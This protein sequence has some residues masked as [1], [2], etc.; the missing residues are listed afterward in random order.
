M[1]YDRAR[2]VYVLQARTF[3]TGLAL[4][5][6][7]VACG[8]EVGFRIPE[9]TGLDQACLA[10]LLAGLA[11]LALKIHFAILLGIQVELEAATGRLT[12][13]ALLNSREVGA[14]IRHVEVATRRDGARELALVASD[15][16]YTILVWP[17]ANELDRMRAADARRVARALRVSLHTTGPDG[18]RTVIPPHDLGVRALAKDETAL[19]AYRAAHDRLVA[20]AAAIGLPRI[21]RAPGRWCASF[22]PTRPAGRFCWMVASAALGAF[23]ALPLAGC[24]SPLEHPAGWPGLIGMCLAWLYAGAFVYFAREELVVGG[25]WIEHRLTGRVARVV[26]AP[27]FF[28]ARAPVTELE[29]A[30][31]GGEGI[32]ETLHLECAHERISVSVHPVSGA[33]LGG[34]L[35]A[36]VAAPE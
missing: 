32:L 26:F 20:R 19:A 16:R 21:A 6:M 31:I 30:W 1:R 13:T 33:D 35:L 23:A 8:I 34:A 15:E 36:A 14:S 28:S 25:G 11:W 4:E 9:A 3:W 24:M 17:A 18:T 29:E 10:A 12:L 7:L 2:G 27:L 5:M 22:P